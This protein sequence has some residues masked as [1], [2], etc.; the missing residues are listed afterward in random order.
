MTVIDI[1]VGH[2]F[3]VGTSVFLIGLLGMCVTRTNIIVLLMS[4]ELML[5]AINF[6][7]IVF[8]VHLDDI[9]GQIFSLFIL[10]V[11]AAEAA[12]GLAVLII[13][14]RLKGIISVN[15]INYIKG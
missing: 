15:F 9:F 12:I 14:Y 5:L 11:A 7:F 3:F 13:Y 10:T 2:F 4:L 6:N 8:S 1:D